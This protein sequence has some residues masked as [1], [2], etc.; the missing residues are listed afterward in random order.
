M[1]IVQGRTQ[2]AI[3]SLFTETL[4]GWRAAHAAT[5][6]EYGS[7]GP[8]G[9]GP[10]DRRCSDA[11]PVALVTDDQPP[12]DCFDVLCHQVSTFLRGHVASQPS[13]LRSR[14]RSIERLRRTGNA[15]PGCASGSCLPPRANHRRVSGRGSASQRSMGA[16]MKLPPRWAEQIKIELG[17]RTGDP[18]PCGL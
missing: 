8:S 9:C 14:M 15:T 1:L 16:P 3:R 18:R 12:G 2:A 7:I 6:V 13:A 11:P 5:Q 10:G 17:S 4:V